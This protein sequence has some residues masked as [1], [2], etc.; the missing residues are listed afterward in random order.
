MGSRAEQYAQAANYVYHQL[1]HQT[2]YE[3]AGKLWQHSERETQIEGEDGT[4]TTVRTPTN[5]WS[6]WNIC[7]DGVYMSNLF[8]IRLAEAIDNGTIELRSE[9]GAPV[10]SEDLWND[11]FTRLTFVMENFRNPKT[12][13]LY[14]GYS[15]ESKTCNGVTWSRGLGWFTMVLVEAAEK[16]PDAGMRS[17]LKDYYA[18]LMTSIIEWQDPDTSL[19]FNVVDR[20]ASL[21]K[22]QPET[23]G[24]AMFAYCLLRGYHAGLL[25]GPEY[26]SAALSAFSS[27]VNTRL[28]DD[29]LTDTLI[30]MGCSS[31]PEHYQNNV[32]V[33]NEAKGV[34]ALIL[35]A[36]Y[37]Y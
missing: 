24:S 6:K 14:H 8:L 36:Q 29:G 21:Y 26:R 9:S 28:T 22:N 34:A 4:V 30:G 37:A 10:S 19:W 27:M 20:D 17:V 31:V 16:M 13:L 15:V 5:S 7:L 11:I 1:E 35:A 2:M 3:D 25:E 23:S 18:S 32:F 12:G 33:T